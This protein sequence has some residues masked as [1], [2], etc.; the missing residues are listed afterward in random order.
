MPTFRPALLPISTL[1][2]INFTH[3]R[4]SVI[5]SDGRIVDAEDPAVVLDKKL[6][7]VKTSWKSFISN[8]IY[9]VSFLA[10]VA[11][12]GW[13][14]WHDGGYFGPQKTDIPVHRW[15]PASIVPELF[16]QKLFVRDILNQAGTNSIWNSMK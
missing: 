15:A 10:V 9:V 5:L 2:T 16:K 13:I 14:S 7:W 12:N 8:W 4:K 6:R 3:R 1:A 11:V